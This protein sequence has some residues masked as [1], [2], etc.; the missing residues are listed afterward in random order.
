V[1]LEAIK[2]EQTVAELAAKYGI[3]PTM[4]TTWKKQ[5]IEGMSSTFSNKPAKE[6]KTTAAEV[7][8]LHAKIGQLV[9]ERDFLSK[10]FNR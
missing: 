8:R 2:G 1:A 4:I 10:A 5:G 7:E 3:H 9:V 6:A